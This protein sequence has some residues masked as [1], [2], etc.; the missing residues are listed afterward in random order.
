MAFRG[1]P[2][3]RTGADCGMRNKKLSVVYRRWSAK[4]FPRI[5]IVLYR[6]FQHDLFG[7]PVSTF[8]HHAP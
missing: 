6:L 4:A 5:L 8:P 2:A 7:K 1:T 3:A